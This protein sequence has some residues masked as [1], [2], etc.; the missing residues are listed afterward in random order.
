MKVLDRYSLLCISVSLMIMMT[1]LMSSDD[2]SDE[3]GILGIA[4]DVRETQNGYTFHFDDAAGDT[5]R[6]FS[7]VE[8]NEYDVYLIE[9]IM[10]EDGGMFFI[11]SLEL[12]QSE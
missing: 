3:E 12:I 10:S 11:S 9:G 8:P 4:Y 7:R 2:L 6:C 1:I 5:K